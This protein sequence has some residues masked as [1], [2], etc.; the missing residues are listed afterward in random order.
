MEK[1]IVGCMDRF[2]KIHC[3][4]GDTTRWICTVREGRLT[5]KQTTSRPDTVWPDMWK[6]ISDASKRKEKQ[7]WAIEKPKLD[8]ARRLH[9]ISFIDPDYEEFERT[10]KNARGKLENPM[11]A[12]MLCRLQL[13]Q[14]WETCDTVGQLKT[15]HASI[16]D[17]DESVRIRMV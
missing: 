13:D 7:K 8:N 4:E 9:V 1:R 3:I 10:M 6:H 5:R 11:P 15:Q 14:H 17:A 12:G 16:V 2:H